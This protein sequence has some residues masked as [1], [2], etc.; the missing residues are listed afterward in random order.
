M[1][2]SNVQTCLL[3]YNGMNMYNTW[4]M[5]RGDSV[6]YWKAWKI[7]LLQRPSTHRRST[8]LFVSS[9]FSGFGMFGPSPSPYPLAFSARHAW[10]PSH[11]RLPGN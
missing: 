1:M 4:N 3:I 11:T 10:L 8:L 2:L 7:V 9:S 6:K 5:H